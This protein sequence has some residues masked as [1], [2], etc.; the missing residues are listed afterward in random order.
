[1]I[2]LPSYRNNENVIVHWNNFF[3]LKST[4]FEFIC[5]INKNS[6]SWSIEFSFYAKLKENIKFSLVNKF[7]WILCLS[8]TLSGRGKARGTRKGSYQFFPCYFSC[9]I[10]LA[11]KTFWLLIL[12]LL[13]NC[14][15]I[16]RRYLVPVLNYWTWTKITLW[17][18]FFMKSL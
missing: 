16:S 13:P 5:K 9:N 2:Y 6:E 7:L 10:E 12:I 3:H 18:M 17:Q 11:L 8:L 15:K 14:C 1:M 4:D